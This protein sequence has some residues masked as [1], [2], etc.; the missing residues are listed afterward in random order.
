MAIQANLAVRLISMLHSGTIV[1]AGFEIMTVALLLKKLL[2]FV[3]GVW[4]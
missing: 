3:I 1:G 2:V 4:F